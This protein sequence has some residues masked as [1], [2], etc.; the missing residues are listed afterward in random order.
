M[1]RFRGLQDALEK[2]LALLAHDLEAANAGLVFP[3][4]MDGIETL[5]DIRAE[6][7]TRVKLLVSGVVVS[8]RSK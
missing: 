8:K 3:D 2:E 4:L 1:C 5:T 7:I 6:V